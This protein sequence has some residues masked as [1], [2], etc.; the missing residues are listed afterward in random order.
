[1]INYTIYQNTSSNQWVTFIHG[2]G[3]SSS[4][5]FKQIREFQKYFNVLLL[6]LR[7][8]GDSKKTSFSKKYTFTAIAHDVLEVIDY[9]KIQSSHFI[10]ISLGTIVIRQL[11]EMYPERVES[12]IMGGAI[13]KMNFRSQILMRV[14]NVFKYMLPYLVLYR[15]FAFIIMPKENHKQSR[16]MFINEA[17]KLY[18]KEFIKWFKLTSEINPILRWF[19]Q[20]ELNIPTLYIMGEEDYMFLPTVKK[21]V[22]SH[23]KTAKLTVIE[24]C[25]H[26]V[27]VEQAHIFNKKAIDFLKKLQ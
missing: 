5:W 21:V 6:D 17:K 22:E 14:G 11:A 20:V 25:G 10:G 15:L 27:N 3:G 12:M 13:L 9:L 8:H 23:Y 19:R 24:K 7:G 2:A 4:I 16:L 1:M 18:Q 26:V